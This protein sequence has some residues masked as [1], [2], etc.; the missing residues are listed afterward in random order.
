M[1]ATGLRL[2]F[3]GLLAIAAGAAF[4]IWGKSQPAAFP[5]LTGAT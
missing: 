2:A 5:P 4:Q 1:N 3:A